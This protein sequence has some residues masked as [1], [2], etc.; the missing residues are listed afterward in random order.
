LSSPAWRA[1]SSWCGIRRMSAGSCAA[2]SHRSVCHGLLA[3]RP[4]PPSCDCE[5]RVGPRGCGYDRGMRRPRPHRLTGS[6]P[7]LLAAASVAL[8]GAAGVATLASAS[9]TGSAPN[10]LPSPLPTPTLTL[11]IRTLTP[12]ISLPIPTPSGS[13]VVG[14]ICSPQPRPTLPSLPPLNPPPAPPVGNACPPACLGGGGSSASPS[15]GVGGVGGGA[16]RGGGSPGGGAGGGIQPAGSGG[17]G[18]ARSAPGPGNSPVDG[19]GLTLAQ[20]VAVDQLT[21]L[22]G[23]SFG[24]APYLWPLFLLLDVIAACAVVLA[25]RKS[26][27][28]PGVD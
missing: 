17:N 24:Q 28:A 2:S 4:I 9:T 22:A 13:C 18:S 21:P 19:G 5:S 3:H 8:L 14:I 27:S 12:T 10:A 26:W 7:R 15:A 11:P 25:L 1:R 6:A 23:I 16:A 20:P